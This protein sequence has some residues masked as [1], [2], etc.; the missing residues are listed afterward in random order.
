V[1]MLPSL[2]PKEWEKTFVMRLR[3]YHIITNLVD[4]VPELL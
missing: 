1:H 2:I 4:A 3:R